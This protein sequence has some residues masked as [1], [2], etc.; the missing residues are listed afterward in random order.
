MK[1]IKH[2]QGNHPSEKGEMI[3]KGETEM[4]STRGDKGDKRNWTHMKMGRSRG[5]EKRDQRRNGIKRRTWIIEKNKSRVMLK[6]R[7]IVVRGR[8]ETKSREK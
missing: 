8:Y 2:E 6:E 7:C 3:R 4:S 1:T 5:Q